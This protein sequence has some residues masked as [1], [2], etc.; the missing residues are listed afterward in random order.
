MGFASAERSDFCESALA[1]GPD[2]PTLCEGWTVADLVAHA[3]TRENDLV[4][5]AGVVVPPLASVTEQRN[6]RALQRWGFPGLVELVRQGPPRASFFGLPG[7]DEQANTAEYFIH[8]EDIRRPAG[9]P[10]RPRSPEFEEMAWKRLRAMAR[11]SFRRAVSGVVLERET[12]EQLRANPGSATVT[13]VGVPSE[14]L[15][16]VS[17][18]T[19]D[20]DVLL[21]GPDAAAS[22]LVETHRGI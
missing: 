9:L 15:L 19:R 14:L 21:V 3:W 10:R 22:A 2:S 7:V 20:A 11:L 5:V 17:G 16:F 4:A 6:R 18:R 13:I 12:G 1:A 8:T